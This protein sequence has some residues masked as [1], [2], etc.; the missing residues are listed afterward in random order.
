MFSIPPS[1]DFED[2]IEGARE[3]IGG[4]TRNL[5]RF[6]MDLL[7]SSEATRGEIH[8]RVFGT[9]LYMGNSRI[10]SAIAIATGAVDPETDPQQ[11]YHDIYNYFIKVGIDQH[12]LDRTERLPNLVE[13]LKDAR[14]ACLARVAISQCP[15]PEDPTKRLI[16]SGVLNTEDDIAFVAPFPRSTIEGNPKMSKKAAKR[17]SKIPIYGAVTGIERFKDAEGEESAEYVVGLASDLSGGNGRIFRIPGQDFTTIFTSTI[18]QNSP[19]VA[20]E[21]SA[22]N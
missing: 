2:H 6:G 8:P 17:L 16:T 4:A 18:V 11:A 15:I 12:N 22:K 13:I 20:F 19:N 9:E 3:A 1:G 7:G 21:V 5:I 14:L 10:L